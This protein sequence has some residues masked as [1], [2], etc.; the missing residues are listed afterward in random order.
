M[1]FWCGCALKYVKYFSPQDILVGHSIMFQKLVANRPNTSL[2]VYYG[3]IKT[4]TWLDRQYKQLS[5]CVWRV[6]QVTSN[7]TNILQYVCCCLR[8]EWTNGVVHRPQWARF[9][10]GSN[11][12]KQNIYQQMSHWDSRHSRHSMLRSLC[13]SLI[14]AHC[15]RCDLWTAKIFETPSCVPRSTPPARGLGL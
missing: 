10:K 2:T 8:G 14:W 13:L 3:V 12:M 11:H 1:V 7:S 6:P 5:V 15:C 9:K 4:P